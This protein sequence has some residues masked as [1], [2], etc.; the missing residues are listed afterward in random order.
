[1]IDPVFAIDAFAPAFNLS[2]PALPKAAVSFSQML[3]QGK[4]FE[5]LQRE[6]I[7]HFLQMIIEQRKRRLKIYR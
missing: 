2:A 1:M 5:I 4:L 7:Q 6:P 3:R